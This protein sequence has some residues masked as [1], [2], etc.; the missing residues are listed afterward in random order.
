MV[1]ICLLARSR[2]Q[3]LYQGTAGQT[4]CSMSLVWGV[5]V[6]M[7][8]QQHAQHVSALACAVCA[9]CSRSKSHHVA[10]EVL[11]DPGLYNGPMTPEVSRRMHAPGRRVHIARDP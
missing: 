3:A 2:A 5:M 6:L 1:V 7:H 4:A 8:L 9:P 10:A 11:V